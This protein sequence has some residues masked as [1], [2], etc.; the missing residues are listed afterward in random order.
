[1]L[2]ELLL[3]LSISPILLDTASRG[4]TPI[5]IPHQHLPPVETVLFNA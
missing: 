3:A 1:M 5:D 4:Q 2:H